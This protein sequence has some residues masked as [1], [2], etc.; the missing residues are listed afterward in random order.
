M[1]DTSQNLSCYERKI[2]LVRT[3]SRILLNV[4]LSDPSLYSQFPDNFTRSILYFRVQIV[5]GRKDSI[6]DEWRVSD[7]VGKGLYVRIVSTYTSTTGRVYVDLLSPYTLDFT[8][9]RDRRWTV[10]YHS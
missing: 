2:F 5:P 3:I 7:V 8:R 4:L 1:V 9:T 10:G 6:V